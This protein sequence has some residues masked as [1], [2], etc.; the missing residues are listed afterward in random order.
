MQCLKLLSEYQLLRNALSEL[1][2]ND[3][4]SHLMAGIA[5]SN[6]AENMDVRPM[7]LLCAVQL[8]VFVTGLSLVKRSPTWCECLCVI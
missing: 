3:F 1:M 8:V 2:L 7:R 5:V 4:C 6:L